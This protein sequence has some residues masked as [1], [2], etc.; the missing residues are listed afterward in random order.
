MTI[1]RIV[2]LTNVD[3]GE[4]GTITLLH[5]FGDWLSGLGTQ[6]VT[7]PLSSISSGILHL[8]RDK[9]SRQK[10]RTLWHEN[11]IELVAE[12]FIYTRDCFHYLTDKIVVRNFIHI[13]TS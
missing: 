7:I 3:I 8:W 6:T 12:E 4:S 1:L 13:A 10:G 5:H 9:T 2:S 11:E